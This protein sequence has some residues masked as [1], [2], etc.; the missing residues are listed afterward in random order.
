MRGVALLLVVAGCGRFGFLGLGDDTP[1]IDSGDDGPT[2]FVCTF[3]FCDRFESPTLDPAWTVDPGVTVD[4]TR[5][6]S[7]TGSL[8]VHSP[9]FA[10]ASDSYA[11]ATRPVPAAKTFWIRSWFWLSALPAG[12]NGMEL[13]VAEQIGVGPMGDYIFLFANETHVYSQFES[14]SMITNPVTVGNWF[15]LVFQV[16]LSPTTTGSLD[17]TGAVTSSLPNV[18]TDDATTPVSLLAWGIGFSGNN[19]P[20]AQPALD[21][22]IDDVIVHSAPVAC[23][24]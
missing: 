19:V 10:A 20:D 5:A 14:S 22:W 6:H 12:A 18:R 24:D 9:A 17:I 23:T 2:S 7:G 11:N 1:T 16:V 13:L 4:T 8:H 15:C 21:L 3:D